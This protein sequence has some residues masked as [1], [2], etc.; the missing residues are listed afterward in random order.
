MIGQ[1]F[2][3]RAL[4]RVSSPE[5]LDRLVKV[6][7][8][9][10]WIALAGFGTLLAAAVV[11][12]LVARVPTTVEGPGFL[13]REGGLHVGAPLT[14]G[15]VVDVAHATG[16]R[17]AAGE[18]L[19]RVRSADGTVEAVRTPYDGVLIEVSADRGDYLAAGRPLAVVD[20]VAEPLV[21]YAYL[22]QADAKKARV[23]DRAEIAISGA[24]PAEY[25]YLL[26]RVAAVAAYP[27]TQERL[28]SILRDD[29]VLA[30]VGELGP[31]IETLVRLERDSSAPSEFAF[32]VGEG[33]PYPLT[34]GTSASTTVITGEQAPIDNVTG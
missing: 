30:E 7:P 9:R 26:G 19:G 23:G 21:V 13:L 12:A 29:S 14:A 34:I 4:E 11:W 27:A 20:E 15:V 5:E 1:P 28:R 6:A 3:R 10:M 8:P 16:D 17:V 22:P 24:D 18:L 2:R 25:G 31:V 33:P 32:S